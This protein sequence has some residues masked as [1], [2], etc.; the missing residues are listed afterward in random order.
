[1]KTYTKIFVKTSVLFISALTLTNSLWAEAT[2]GSVAADPVTKDEIRV[3][4]NF[5]SLN[6]ES[7]E[8][9]IKQTKPVENIKPMSFTLTKLD[10]C[11]DIKLDDIL[12][13]A[14]SGTEHVIM[15]NL[16]ETTVGVVSRITITDIKTHGGCEFQISF[17]PGTFST[18]GV[19]PISGGEMNNCHGTNGSPH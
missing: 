15:E 19:P 6:L 7:I 10:N 5:D 12:A 14:N 3:C 8:L 17:S 2:S 1:M 4:V 18:G 13:T 11:E 16:A 9:G